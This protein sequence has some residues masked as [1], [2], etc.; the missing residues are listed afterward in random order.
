[1]DDEGGLLFLQE[2]EALANLQF[3]LG[4]AFPESHDSITLP[5]VFPIEFRIFVLK[6]SD[7]ASLLAHDRHALLATKR[8]KGITTRQNQG[9]DAGDLSEKGFCARICQLFSLTLVYNSFLSIFPEKLTRGAPMTDKIVVLSTCGTAEEAERIARR[10]VEKRLAACVNVLADA[11]SIYRW[12]GTI[13]DATETVLIIKSRRDLFDA[14]R[15]ELETVHSYE[16]PE[17]V[18]LSIVEGSAGYLNWMENVL[19]PE[20]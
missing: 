15:A 11:R 6:R 18:A 19:G 3:L 10:L 13:E 1:L 16:V 4:P 2:L 8:E 17:V 20:G 14:L 12:R 7:L 9:K 5:L